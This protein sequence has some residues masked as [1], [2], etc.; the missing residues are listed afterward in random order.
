MVSPLKTDLAGPRIDK[1]LDDV[2]VKE[3]SI[4]FIDGER[5][6]LL[7]RG[8][9]IRD[10]ARHSS[11]EEVVFLLLQGRL[12]KRA[13]RTRRRTAPCAVRLEAASIDAGARAS[14]GRPPHRR[15]LHERLRS[16]AGRFH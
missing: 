4:C 5:G 16:G 3:T 10:L 6:R 11:F 13:D 12:P 15:L 8:Y 7:Y 1:R 2:Y 9:D 14:D